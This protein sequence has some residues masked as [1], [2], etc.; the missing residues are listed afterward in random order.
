MGG[1]YLILFYVGMILS[2]YNIFGKISMKKSILC[3]GV[4]GTLW[5]A[6]NSYSINNWLVIDDKLPWGLGINPPG[7]TLMLSAL[8]MLFFCYGVFT[9]LERQKYTGMITSVLGLI[10]RNTLYIFLYHR[11]YLD[12]IL[13][14]HMPI[15]NIMIRWVVYI[16]VMIFGSIMIEYALVILKKCINSK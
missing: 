13:S 8:F 12:F 6:W 16:F 10:G 2:K 4:F 15:N 11:F 5:V 14:R 9:L 7:I 1:T 3:T